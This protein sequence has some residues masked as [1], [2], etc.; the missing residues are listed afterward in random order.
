MRYP[1]SIPPELP[2]GATEHRLGVPLVDS[3]KMEYPARSRDR[4][5]SAGA[6]KRAAGNALSRFV[7]LDARRS[8][9]NPRTETALRTCPSSQHERIQSGPLA[10]NAD[11]RA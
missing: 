3:R 2:N 4:S 8:A 10:F 1:Q 5:F 9:R 6:E 11:E 7:P